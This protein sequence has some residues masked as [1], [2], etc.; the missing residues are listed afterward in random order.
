MPTL[1][2]PRRRWTIGMLLGIVSY[3][4]VP[5]RLEPIVLPER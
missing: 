1:R 3:V 5:G 2:D 4:F